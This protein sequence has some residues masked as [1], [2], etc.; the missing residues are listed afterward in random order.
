[1]VTLHQEGYQEIHWGQEMEQASLPGPPIPSSWGRY[2]NAGSTQ[3]KQVAL[4]SHQT[5]FKY[6]GKLTPNLLQTV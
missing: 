3:S 4:E 6:W 1:M 2:A 5:E